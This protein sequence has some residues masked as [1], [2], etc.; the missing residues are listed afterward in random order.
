MKKIFSL[1]IF[2]FLF[3]KISNAAWQT[4]IIDPNLGSPIG[5]TSIALD[6][7]NNPHISYYDGTNNYPKYAKW[8]GSSWS[9]QSV[10]SAGGVGYDTSIALDSNNYPHISYYDYTNGDLK[11]AKW[12]YVSVSL[13]DVY[14]IPN[15]CYPSKGCNAVEFIH[16]PEYTEI[17]IFSTEGEIVRTLSN[18]GSPTI[19]FDF[20]NNSGQLL[21]DGIYYAVVKDT[22]TMESKTLFLLKG[23]GGVGQVIES[24]IIGISPNN[25]T[26][27]LYD[28]LGGYV[29]EMTLI[30][31]PKEQESFKTT[32]GDN[33]FNPR[34][35]GT[36]KIKFNVPSA[37]R[38]S[39]KI[40]D[41]SGKLI[42][43]L[44][45]SD[46]GS[47]D[48]QKDWDGK[49]DSGRYVVP[50]IYFL[51]YVY[52]GGKEVRKIGVRK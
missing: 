41:I 39:L 34:T 32:L 16:I 40:Y 3:E 43:T 14:S 37:G 52:P 6:T 48:F 42:R 46:S 1:T 24:E 49:D 33:L 15:P 5:C 21:S 2:L 4:E 29:G 8:T 36:A 17:K 10:D 51:H 13:D 27:R 22:V 31:K 44:F 7:N 12:I 30:V 19:N 47:G 18:S 20:K 11:Y 28:D 23:L 9:I 45:E 38:V 35:G 26:V 50:G 25:Y